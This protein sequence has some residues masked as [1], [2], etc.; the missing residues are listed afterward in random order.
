M[1]KFL[2]FILITF[3][4]AALAQHQDPNQLLRSA[5]AAQQSGDLTTAIRDYRAILVLR[6]KS[7]EAHVNLGAALAQHA[8]FPAAIAELNAALPFTKPRHQ[9]EIYLNLGL[10]DYKQSLYA[11]AIPNLKTALEIQPNNIQAAT[12]L[13][14]CQLKLNNPTAALAVTEPRAALADQSTDFA[15]AYAVALLRT[16]HTRDGAVILQHLVDAGTT[17][18]VDLLAGT[19]WLQ[20]T[21]FELARRDLEAAHTTDPKLPGLAVTLGIARDRTGDTFAAEAAFREALQSQP[22]D[23]EIT[24]QLVAVLLK[25]RKFDDARHFLARVLALQPNSAVALYEDGLLL[26]ETG[27]LEASVNSLRKSIALNPTSLDPHTLLVSILSKL[28]RTDEAAAER[29]IVDKLTAEQK[30]ASTPSKP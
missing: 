25:R 1:R 21:E 27:N 4:A 15:Y 10:I 28:D 5:I 30:A 12:L 18:D 19:T 23:P 13:A 6:P 11:N 9:G 2:Q 24:L 20:L 8:E 17:P 22:D 29:K 7:A 3:P 26:S 16:N 14:N